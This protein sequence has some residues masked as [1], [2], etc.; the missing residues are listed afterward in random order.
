[1]ADDRSELMQRSVGVAEN[2]RLILNPVVHR[3]SAPET[4]RNR[5]RDLLEREAKAQA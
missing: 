2:D 1:V 4:V 5:I 3:V